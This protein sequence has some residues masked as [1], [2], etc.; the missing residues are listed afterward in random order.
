MP[1]WFSAWFGYGLG[2]KA[3][4][5]VLGEDDPSRGAAERGPIRPMTEEEIRAD[6]R[7]FAEDEKR[8]NEADAAKR[9]RRG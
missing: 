7:R 9:D 1:G 6:E 2:K 8:L 4:S 5:L 3:A